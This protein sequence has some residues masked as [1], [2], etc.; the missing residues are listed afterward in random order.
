MA[1]AGIKDGEIIVD[2]SF[3]QRDLMLQVP[4]SRWHKDSQLWVLPLTWAACLQL[5]GLFRDNLD[6]TDELQKWAWDLRE[7]RIEPALR[8]REML[9]PEASTESESLFHVKH[10]LEA[11]EAGE[12]RLKPFQV[13]D[14]AFLVTCGQAGLFNQPGSGKSPVTIRTLQVLNRMG[15]DPFPALI[16]CPNSLKNTVWAEE[17]GRWAPELTISVVSGPIGMRRRQIQVG[18]DVTVI[19]Y[20]SVRLHTHEAGYGTIRLTE[21]Q[22]E[23]KEL[24]DVGYRTVI[25]DEAHRLRHPET[26][27]TRACWA[28]LHDAEF[29]FLLTGTPVNDHAGDL[30][31]L[32][33]G[34]QP[35]WHPR[36]T[37]YVSRYCTPPD[38]PVLMANGTFKAI[39][40]LLPG[41]QVMGFDRRNTPG[42]IKLQ[43]AEVTAVNRREA[44][45]VRVTMASGRN[46]LCTPDHQ[47]L[48]SRKYLQN[49]PV[50][51]SG[52]GRRTLAG[53]EGKGLC[54][55]GRRMDPGNLAKHV[56]SAQHSVAMPA[57]RVSPKPQ[58]HPERAQWLE[59]RPP[60]IGRKLVR[61]VDVPPPL[62]HEEQLDAAWLGGIF[63]GEGSASG[64]TV[65]IAQYSV[66]NPDIYARIEQVL[67]KLGFDYHMSDKGFSLRGGRDGL[68]RFLHYCRP[69]KGPSIADGSRYAAKSL[70]ARGYF[71][72]DEIVSIEPAGVSPVVSLTTTTGTYVV[73]GFASSN[74]EVGYN[75]FGGTQILGLR[76]DTSREFKRITEPVYRRVLK[77]AVLPQL[78]PKLPPQ[79]R[80]TPMTPKQA[81]AY[82]SM[83]ENLLTVVDSGEILAAPSALAQMTRLLQ[84]ASATADIDE[85]GDVQ[86]KDPSAK[87][88]DLVEFLDELGEDE[89]LVVAAVSRKL[90]ELAAE[91]LKEKKIRYGLVTG[92]QST[93]ERARAVQEFQDGRSRAILLTL[94]AGA[95]GITLTRANTILFMQKSWSPQV[96]EQA[97]DRIHRIGSE[98][99]SAIRIIEQVTPATVES[100]VREILEVKS[101]RIEEVLSDRETLRRLLGRN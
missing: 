101:W 58:K 82:K 7:N 34:M 92:A 5:R 29:R 35:D 73:H 10:H 61:V 46:F 19:N 4:G 45:V 3:S 63:D 21:K 66:A 28:V 2:C 30:W 81:K 20:E 31:G 26:S 47:W 37:R 59:F 23:R 8:L 84:F 40:D 9:E 51:P 80:E 14:T 67:K 79:V 48:D 99:H 1:T 53:D 100:R 22:K 50:K 38:S 56:A 16:I 97:V 33:H 78:P 36:Y 41:D 12:L 64:A 43:S 52:A 55:C 91:R 77:E 24:N 90:I 60:V 87:V 57:K 54:S 69:V 13:V 39:G 71:Q 89:P 88:D 15:L 74:C 25:C 17:L 93:V 6:L 86:L 32:L 70:Q 49:N 85:H 76:P 94:G 65:N 42:S 68:V 18:A 98:I 27:M 96:N 75:W 83:E 44:E 72:N 95:E 11:L 62:T